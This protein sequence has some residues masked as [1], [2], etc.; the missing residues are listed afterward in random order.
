MRRLRIDGQLLRVGHLHIDADQAGNADYLAAPTATQSFSVSQA[1]QVITFT[2]SP[3]NPAYLGTYTVS[4][5]G[6][7]SGNPVIVSVDSSA[8]KVCSVSG[9]TAS[10]KALGRCVLDANQAGN[11]DYLV[12]VQVQQSFSVGKATPVLT[13]ATPAAITY[14]A[15]LGGSQLDA[16][17]SVAG[18]FVYNPPAG[19]VLKAGS[20]LLSA[21]F[22]PTDSVHY[23]TTTTAVTL[24]VNQA[25]PVADGLRQRRSPI[26]RLCR[27]PSSTPP[28]LCPAP[29]STASHS[30]RCSRPGPTA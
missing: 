16:K 5:T 30:G 7:G 8:T 3:S 25:K 21:T 13:W 11:T 20:D 29:S 18:Q 17:A 2:S 28:R 23:A 26:R 27:R 1:P 12:A 4:A 10:F 22:T 19:T 6:G 15:K 24:V 9:S 14:G